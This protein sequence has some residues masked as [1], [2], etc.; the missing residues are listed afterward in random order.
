MVINLSGIKKITF[1]QEKDQITFQGGALVS[2]IVSAAYAN[3]TRVLTG[4]CNCIGAL[5]AV[6]GGGYGRLMG[7]YGFGI[8]NLISVNL[9]TSYG[10]SIKVDASNA[11]LWWALKG[12]GANFGIVTSATM[13]A[14]PTPQANNT[15]WLGPLIFTEDKIEQLVTAIN[16]LVLAPPMAIFMYY[17][18][19]GA[20][21]YEPIIIALPF[22]VGSEVAGRAAFASILAVGPVQD[23]TAVT[24]YDEWNAGSGSFCVKGDRKPN[25]GAGFNVMD[26]VTWRAIWNEYT[27]FLSANPGTGNSTVLVE[28]YSL[29]YAQSIPA[30][31]ASFPLRNGVRFNG[32]ATA[33]YA[34]AS[35]DPVAEKFGSTVRDLW[36]AT[37]DLSQNKT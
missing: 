36:R 29:G 10:V 23:L 28:Y 8:D 12:A 25:Y 11:D 16:N 35:L 3:N 18:T 24:P 7:F 2:D 5:G 30:S 26:P 4:N 17:A 31:S 20:P 14:Y 1:S 21:A 9:V 6:L 19:S 27:G 37:D 32:V 15:A 34:D 22:Y 13:K 33:W